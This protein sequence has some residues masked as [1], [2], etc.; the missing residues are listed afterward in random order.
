MCVP[1]NNIAQ[2]AFAINRKFSNGKSKFF[3]NNI[4]FSILIQVL[5]ACTYIGS[6]GKVDTDVWIITVL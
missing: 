5:I 2:H 1:G 3:D 6:S 4:F